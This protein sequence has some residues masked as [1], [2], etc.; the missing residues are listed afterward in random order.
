MSDLSHPDW[1]PS[2]WK[3]RAG[4][5]ASVCLVDSAG[6]RGGFTVDLAKEKSSLFPPASRSAKARAEVGNS[7][8]L[9]LTPSLLPAE[10]S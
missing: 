4:R 7:V 5:K 2:Q 9:S 8:L 10:L 6:F 3:G 1:L